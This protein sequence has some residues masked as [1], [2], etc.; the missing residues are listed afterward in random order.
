MPASYLQVCLVTDEIPEGEEPVDLLS[1]TVAGTNFNS[2]SYEL[3]L[4]S[5]FGVAIRCWSRAVGRQ[6][7]E[8]A[9]EALWRTSIFSGELRPTASKH[10]YKSEKK[11]KIHDSW[12]QI[13][14]SVVA[15]APAWSMMHE[16]HRVQNIRSSYLK[17]N[18]VLWWVAS[19]LVKSQQSWRHILKHALGDH[20]QE[21][22]VKCITPYNWA[23]HWCHMPP[24]WIEAQDFKCR[25]IQMRAS[26][27]M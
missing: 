6:S 22:R 20:D 23:W 12:N 5:L 16:T 9:L 1:E 18:L 17:S 7:H 26:W 15:F 3:I 11:C 2:T 8:V 24:D 27:I 19:L 10:L 4:W 13:V 14:R 25:R 21:L